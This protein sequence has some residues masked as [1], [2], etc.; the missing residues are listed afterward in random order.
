MADYDQHAADYDGDMR[1]FAVEEPVDLVICPGR[2]LMHC[3][4][5]QEIHGAPPD[6]RIAPIRLVDVAGH[7]D[8]TYEMAWIARKPDA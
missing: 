1:D 7:D 2:S 4:T 5:W 8:T 3:R 6:N